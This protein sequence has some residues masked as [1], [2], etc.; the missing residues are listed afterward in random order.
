MAWWTGKTDIVGIALGDSNVVGAG[1]FQLGVQTYNTAL[2]CYATTAT[3]PYNPAELEWRTL[4]PN[5]T[6]RYDQMYESLTVQDTTYIGQVLGGNGAAA[7]MLANVIQQETAC[8]N[9]WLYQGAQGGSTSVDWSSGSNWTT[10][11]TYL[12]AALAD[13][14]GS[15]TY[16]D[17]IYISL[18]AADHIFDARSAEDY[19]QNM[20]TLR[21]NMISEGWWVPGTTQI[22]IQDTPR[23]P[24]MGS[25]DG[26]QLVRTRFNDRIEYINSVGATFL[27]EGIFT[28]HYDPPTLTDMG[29]RGGNMAFAQVPWQQSTISAG[30]SRIST[31]GQKIRVHSA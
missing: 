3:I 20:V 11:Q 8:D 27:D 13:V 22:L 30:G 25:W 1:G 21:A 31:G 5:G 23:L 26:V 15:P 9:F 14:P 28:V 2:R 19:Y 24:I 29:E 4:D 12:P 6:S 16:A 18:G 10:M 17:V 7:M